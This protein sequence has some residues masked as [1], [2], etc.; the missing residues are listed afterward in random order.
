[1]MAQQPL[2][3][4]FFPNV[5]EGLIGR[6]G[7]ALPGAANPPTSIREGV[8]RRWAAALQEAVEQTGGEP[9]DPGRD[10]RGGTPHGLHLNYDIDFQSRRVGDITPTL[11]SQRHEFQRHE[12]HLNHCCCGSFG[13]LCLNISCGTFFPK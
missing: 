6:L 11:L 8:V 3:A 5:L 7:L 13:F 9:G 4:D 1:M 12:F 2:E 10:P